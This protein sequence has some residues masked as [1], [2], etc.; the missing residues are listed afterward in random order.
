MQ[1]KYDYLS[2]YIMTFWNPDEA[3]LYSS[4]D[5]GNSFAGKGFQVMVVLDI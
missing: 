5:G 1:L 4:G 3:V 2:L